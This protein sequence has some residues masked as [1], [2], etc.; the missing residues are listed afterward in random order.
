M[1][2]FGLKTF[3]KVFI[4]NSKDIYGDRRVKQDRISS[5]KHFNLKSVLQHYNKDLKKQKIF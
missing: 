3:Q 4:K 1:N 5:V 2:I